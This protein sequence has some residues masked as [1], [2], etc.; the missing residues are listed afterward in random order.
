MDASA[1]GDIEKLQDVIRQLEVQNEKLR[2]RGSRQN[3]ANPK[4]KVNGH[5]SSAIDD[6]TLVPILSDRDSI[7]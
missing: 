3:T 6:M 4:G 7:R 2:S 5:I 1:S